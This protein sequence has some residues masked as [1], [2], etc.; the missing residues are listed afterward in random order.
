MAEMDPAQ[1]DLQTQLETALSDPEL[2]ALYFNGFMTSLGSGDVTLVLQRN[3]KPVAVLN[4]SYTIAKTLSMR[5]RDVIAS[6]EADARHTILT[7]DD[8]NRA[9]EARRSEAPAAE[10]AD[11]EHG[12]RL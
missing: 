11:G 1:Q 9:V 12:Q 5:L 10:E 7:T 6:L 2:P 4:A 8:I 3:G